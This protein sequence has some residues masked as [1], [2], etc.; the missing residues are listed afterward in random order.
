M[1]TE[2]SR[3]LKQEFDKKMGAA[4]PEFQKIGTAFGGVI[5]RKAKDE[6]GKYLFVFM[7]PAPKL[8]R[9]TLELGAS[10]TP[11]FPFHILPG[12]V[13]A[14]GAVRYRIRKFLDTKTEGWWNL[15]ESHMPD[16]AAIMKTFETEEIRRAAARIPNLVDNAFQG[17]LSAIPKFLATLQ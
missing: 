17:L 2:L 5:Y 16:F 7:M 14:T 9:F 13:D 6:R 12:E 4:L 15:N 10:T 11:D 1:K 3:I 8:D